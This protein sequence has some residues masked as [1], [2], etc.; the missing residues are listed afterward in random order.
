MQCKLLRLGKKAGARVWVPKSDQKKM[1][2]ACE[3]TNF[4]RVFSSG[5]DVPGMFVENID[6]IWNE[7][8]NIHA[9]FEVENSTSVYSGLLRF[10]DLKVMAPNHLYPLFIVAPLSR[11][12]IARQQF[13]R[14]T[15][16][17]L[18]FDKE[19]RYLSYQAVDEVD[20][21]VR[22]AA[23]VPRVVELLKEKSELLSAD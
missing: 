10:S 3:P 18:G 8:F 5:L 12:N 11:K 17:R 21:A 16:G 14:P 20:N 19:F 6:V 2:E 23:S 7:E 1:Q 22:S 9:A 15:F 13:K 4:P